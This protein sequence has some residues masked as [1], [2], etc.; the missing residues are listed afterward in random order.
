MRFRPARA[1]ARHR[2]SLAAT[3]PDG[4]TDTH[5]QATVAALRNFRCI[6]TGTHKYI[7]NYNDCD[8]LY[9]LEQ[10]P[11]ELDNIA[12]TAPDVVGD[13]ARRLRRRLG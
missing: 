12:A 6:R 7:Q 3:D 9:D 5:R 2:R 4:Q 11:D 13:L 8:E 1:A 10:D